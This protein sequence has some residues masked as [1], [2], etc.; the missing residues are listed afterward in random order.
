MIGTFDYTL[1]SSTSFHLGY[2]SLNFNYQASGSN[3]GFNVHMKGPIL[4]ATLSF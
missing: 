2:R 4:A 1:N 3:L